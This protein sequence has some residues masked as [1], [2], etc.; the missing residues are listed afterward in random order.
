MSR[1]VIA[2]N[3]I[4]YV[5]HDVEDKVNWIAVLFQQSV[6]RASKIMDGSVFKIMLLNHSLKSCIHSL[7]TRHT[8][9]VFADED[10][11]S[12]PASKLLSL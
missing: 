4:V 3:F 8:T 2:I 5:A 11:F 6:E 9:A 7:G 10:K 1:V 12:Q